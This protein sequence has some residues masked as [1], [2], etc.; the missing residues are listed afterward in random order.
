MV[1]GLAKTKAGEDRLGARL[2][3]PIDIVVMV[4]FT[5]EGEFPAARGDLEHGLLANRGAFLR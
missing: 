3:G 5:L 4:V 1:I 2:Q